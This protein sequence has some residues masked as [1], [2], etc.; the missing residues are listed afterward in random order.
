MTGEAPSRERVAGR[1][2]RAIC[3]RP[4]R[5]WEALAPA[6]LPDGRG[7]YGHD[8]PAQDHLYH[9]ERTIADGLQPAGGGAGS[10][11]GRGRQDEPRGGRHA[12]PGGAALRGRKLE[13]GRRSG[14]QVDEHLVADAARDAV[15][16]GDDRRLLSGRRPV[17]RR[18]G[19][20]H[21]G[22]LVEQPRR[23]ER[24]RARQTADDHG[25]QHGHGR[26]EPGERGNDRLF[27]LPPSARFRRTAGRW[28]CCGCR[29]P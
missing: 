20:R 19:T 4:A 23:T 27:D 24:N 1:R 17:C 26:L 3:P 29:W 18:E 22:N 2:V 5:P 25:L 11:D 8:P 9:G 6:P 7:E 14:E 16:V 28:P 12:R 15:A 21:A 13:P 10:L